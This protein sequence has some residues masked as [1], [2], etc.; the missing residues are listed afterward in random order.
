MGLGV[1]VQRSGVFRRPTFG[2]W[3]FG[4]RGF[5][6]AVRRSMGLG[7]GFGGWHWW[8]RVRGSKSGG[9][10]GLKIEVMDRGSEIGGRTEAGVVDR[11]SRRDKG[12]RS[13]VGV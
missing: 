4:G 3:D 13:V 2:G 12:R 7:L 1:R 5:G 8:V 9:S 6:V 11:R 10:L